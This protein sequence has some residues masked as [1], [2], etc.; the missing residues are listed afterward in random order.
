MLNS[1]SIVPIM[2]QAEASVLHLALVAGHRPRVVMALR[3]V[4]EF[5]HDLPRLDRHLELG[6]PQVG[7]VYELGLGDPGALRPVRQRVA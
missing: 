2:R 5:S 3:L 1:V 4:L 7:V 6:L